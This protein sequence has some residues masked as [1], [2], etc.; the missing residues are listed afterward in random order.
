V[1]RREA[2]RT[3]V[4]DGNVSRD[5]ELR[6][7]VP[8]WAQWP[9]AVRLAFVACPGLDDAPGSCFTL[10]SDHNSELGPFHRGL[11]GMSPMRARSDMATARP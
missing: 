4:F 3:R 9:A 7:A 10:A 8:S 11:P 2:V 1:C 5:G 6:V